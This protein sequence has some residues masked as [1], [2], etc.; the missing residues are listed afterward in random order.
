MEESPKPADTENIV[1]DIYD[2]YNDTQQEVLA[3][4]IR[5]ARNKLFTVA[6]VLLI[7]NLLA[8]MISGIPIS[9]VIGDILLFPVIFLGLG[10]LATKEP[11]VA[12][13]LGI[14][15]MIGYWIYIAVALDIS[16]LLKG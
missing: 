8:V 16:F 10:F 4:E 2:G 13:V 11:L 9:Y 3:I 5:K 6:A 15:I 12:T 7:F 1:A 14:L